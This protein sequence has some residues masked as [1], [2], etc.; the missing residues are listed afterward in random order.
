[1]ST[2]QTPETNLQPAAGY[3]Y[4]AENYCAHH[5]LTNLERNLNNPLFNVHVLLALTEDEDAV[6]EAAAEHME[7]DRHNPYSYDSDVFPKPFTAEEADPDEWCGDC[8]LRFIDGEQLLPFTVTGVVLQNGQQVFGHVAVGHI[9]HAMYACFSEEDDG[10]IRWASHVMAEDP[11]KAI[12]KVQEKGL[13]FD[14]QQ[15]SV[16]FPV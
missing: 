10:I 5:A 12:E 2:D 13:H 6:F 1:M 3:T 11:E 15:P 7:I 8:G 14:E 9:G 4:K 16:N